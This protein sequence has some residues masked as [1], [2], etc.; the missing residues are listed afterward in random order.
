MIPLM[1]KSVFSREQLVLQ[2]LLVEA[3]RSAGLRQVDLA[4]KLGKP[5]PFV[6]RYESGEKMLDLPELRQVC[7]ALGV[8]LT[9]FVR[10]YEETLA[11]R[12]RTGSD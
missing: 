9:E 12:H 8:D 10:R 2:E 1:K 4:E 5:Q 7:L 6:S 11:A 3:R